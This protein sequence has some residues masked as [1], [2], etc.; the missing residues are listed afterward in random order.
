M[1]HRL[2]IVV[3]LVAAV[4][5]TVA[6]VATHRGQGAGSP[7]LV[8]A[9]AATF[10]GLPS[11]VSRA[12]PDGTHQHTLASGSSPQISPDGKLVAFT[13]WSDSPRTSDIFVVRASGGTPSLLEHLA[14]DG[15]WTNIMPVWAPDSRHLVAVE[16]AGV[17][18][19]DAKADTRR[20]LVRGRREIGIGTLSFSPE[21]R[22]FAYGTDDTTGGDV[23]VE[24]IT[25]GR[26]RR[27]THDHKSFMPL[28]GQHGIAY[29]RGGFAHGDIWMISP[30]GN[31]NRRLTHTNAGIYPAFFSADGSRLLAANP[32][33]HNGR[34][35]AVDAD[36]GRARDLTGWRGDLFPQGLSRD[37]KM[38]LAAIGCGGMV[39]PFGIVETLPFGGGKPNVIARGPC[40]ASWNR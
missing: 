6:V 40:R 10:S 3:G 7:A 22:F 13:R 12:A 38:I 25:G 20:V 33:T 28:W 37:G 27:I 36:S 30:R 16:Q 19:F 39:S 2:P 5:A 8:Y 24:S 17:V 11:T 14:G 32:A 29:N 15:I 9:E 23:Y 35:W 4:V 1:R 34:L 21:S 18:I 26:P 31:R